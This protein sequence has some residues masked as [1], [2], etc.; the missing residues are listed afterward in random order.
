MINPKLSIITINRNNA[1]GLRKTIGSVVSQTYTN[2]E[3][4]II[5]GAS[6]DGSVDI[7]K[8]YADRITYW[9]SEPDTGIYNAMNKGILKANGEYLQFL[10][11]GDWLFN[12]TVLR[13]V[14]D[15]HRSEDILYGCDMLYY[16]NDKVVF[17][18]YPPQL[19]FLFMISG[20]ISHQGTFLK[21]NLFENSLYN[22]QY[23]IV[24]DYD[25][26]IKNIVI[27]NCS[28]FYLDFPI[29]YFD[30]YGI[31]MSKD[32]ETLLWNERKAVLNSYF[33]EI[34]LN[35]MLEYNKLHS[36]TN[37]S[38]YP[39]VEIFAKHPR[40]QRIVRRFMKLLLITIRKKY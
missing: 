16:R 9:V 19:T 2:F 15:L 7:I 20:T 23:K 37:Y 18:A 24:S 35:D 28:T 17:K 3:Y 36:I 38:L 6:T 40:L 11:S 27:K 13:N 8:E 29:V 33:P 22:E 32:N 31:S 14:F 26:Y 21:R 30:M 39:Y 12:E 1:D 10:N 4:I 25:F 5:D 34:V